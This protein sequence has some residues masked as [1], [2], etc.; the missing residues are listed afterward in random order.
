VAKVFPCGPLAVTVT[1]D[2]AELAEQARA[3]LDLYTAPWEVPL[4]P[5]SIHLQRTADGQP[6]V[7]ASFLSCANMQVAKEADGLSATCSSGASGRYYAARRHWDMRVPAGP[8]LQELPQRTQGDTPDALHFRDR[9][10]VSVEDLVGLA[11]VTGWRE[12]GWVPLHAGGVAKTGCCAMVVAP[13][14]G[15][16]TTFTVAMLHRGWSALGDDKLLLRLNADGRAEARGLVHQF[17]LDPQAR[18]WFPEVGDLERL[19]AYSAW[20]SKRRLAIESVWPGRAVS[21]GSPTYLLNL[22]RREEPGPVE[23]TPL[24]AGDVLSSLLHQTVIPEDRAAARQV[25]AVMAGLARHLAGLSVTLGPDAYDDIEA[26]A[27]LEALLR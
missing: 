13:S 16:K 21:Q 12:A 5:I 24:G 17:N 7:T 2:G 4:A 8:A 20:T 25:L 6:P 9:L 19:P 15:G 27:K 11:L 23:V 26:L 22:L 14:G 1:A 3:I 18:R 10:G